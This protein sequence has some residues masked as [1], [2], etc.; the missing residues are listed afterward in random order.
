MKAGRQRKFI[1]SAARTER[2]HLKLSWLLFG[3]AL[4]IQKRL[5]ASPSPPR[6]V[7]K[8]TSLRF[9]IP[10]VIPS[11]RARWGV[12]RPLASKSLIW[13]E[14]KEKDFYKTVREMG[15]DLERGLVNGQFTFDQSS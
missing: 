7:G 4:V 15:R 8:P 5:Q 2:E 12:G 3:S 6:E 10:G 13:V 9:L 14:A 1:S 11:F